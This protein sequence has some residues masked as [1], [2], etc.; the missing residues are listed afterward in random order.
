MDQTELQL[1]EKIIALHAR[2]PECLQ[3]IVGLAA[4]RPSEYKAMMRKWEQALKKRQKITFTPEYNNSSD[5]ILTPQIAESLVDESRKLYETVTSSAPL[6]KLFEARPLFSEALPSTLTTFAG[7]ADIE[8]DS[9]TLLKTQDATFMRLLT[10][11]RQQVSP[12]VEELLLEDFAKL[13]HIHEEY[14]NIAASL[15]ELARTP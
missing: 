14:P 9:E 5:E 4:D 1:L 2:D 6:R 12:S 7:F 3:F 11:A 10:I 15:R 8:P 13:I